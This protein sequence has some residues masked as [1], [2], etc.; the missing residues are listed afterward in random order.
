MQKPR[1]WPLVVVLALWLIAFV[2]FRF[3]SDGDGQQKAFGI[4]SATLLVGFCAGLWFLFFSRLP[5]KVRLM[6]LGLG[7]VLALVGPRFVELR[8]VSGDFVPI[9][10][11]RS[12]SPQPPA[13]PPPIAAPAPAPAAA[14]APTLEAA[15]PP[16]AT[17]PPAES[18]PAEEAPAPPAAPVE[19]PAPASAAPAPA[20]PAVATLEHLDYPQF[21]GP[22]R[23][24][25]LPGVRLA[26]DWKARPPREL[27]RRPMGAGWAGFSVVGGRLFTL[28]QH[29]PDEVA[30][31]YALATGEP[32]WSH[33]DAALYAN[34]IGGDGPRTVPTVVGEQV[35]VMGATSQLRALDR[36]TGQ[37][38]WLRDLTAEHAVKLPEWGRSSSPLVVDGR[39]IVQV[40]A[41]ERGALAAYDAVTGELVWTGGNDGIGYASPILAELAG[42]RQV[43]S[44]NAGSVTG[45]RLAD[46]QE[47]WRFAWPNQQVNV[48]TPLVLPGDRVFASS[49]YGVGGKLFAVSREG[50]SWTTKLLWESPRLKAKFTNVVV[51]GEFLY[52][53]DDG[54]LTCIDLATGERRWKAGRYGH[55]Q[56]L[57]VG[58]LLLVQTEEGE[59]VLVDPNP[60]ALTELG[61][62]RAFEG[63]TWNP[64]TFAA[65]YLV[66]RT[67]REAAVFELPM[68]E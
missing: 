65:P 30:T 34:V 13:L 31:S 15:V 33:K 1:W 49:G 22:A 55:G 50:D 53:L 68:A 35:F 6:G 7:V 56:V 21:L 8:G 47:L 26:R 57:L 19:A 62:F 9:F 23:D 4:L 24:G 32:I 25:R 27:W 43:V 41:G 16:V 44:F 2:Y 5:G 37:L 58:E 29:G 10:G 48:S 54:V 17:V 18:A 59:I 12:S 46:G 60:E 52:G 3:L 64:L 61:S 14:P 40:G 28:E 39:V 66:L 67:D 11:W 63:K 36:A 42:E 45:H 38:R 20:A 51:Q